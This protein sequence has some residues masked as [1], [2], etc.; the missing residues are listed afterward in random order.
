MVQGYDIVRTTDVLPPTAADAEI[1]EVARVEN[2][3]ILT[4]DLDFSM[5]VALGNYGLPSLITLR[6]SSVKPEKTPR[7]FTY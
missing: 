3:V 6:L 1:L 7:C 4:Q 5:L 2:R